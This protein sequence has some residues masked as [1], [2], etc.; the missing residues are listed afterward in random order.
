MSTGSLR[1]SA[2][3]LAEVDNGRD[4]EGA[5]ILG[6]DCQAMLCGVQ[7][8]LGIGIH[9]LVGLANEGL[10]PSWLFP[11]HHTQSDLLTAR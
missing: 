8:A 4:Q 6:F 2:T 5:H 7:Y 3:S 1:S 9:K 10:R 11:R